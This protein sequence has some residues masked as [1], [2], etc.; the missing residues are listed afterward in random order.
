MATS[1]PSTATHV[2]PLGELIFPRSFI[3]SHGTSIAM[4]VRAKVALALSMGPFVHGEVSLAFSMQTLWL[5]KCIV[6]KYRFMGP[7]W[8]TFRRAMWMLLRVCVWPNPV[9]ARALMWTMLDPVLWSSF[10]HGN[11]FRVV[12][13]I[14]RLMSMMVMDRLNLVFCSDHVGMICLTLPLGPTTGPMF[15]L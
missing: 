14:G 9:A 12:H 5:S 11:Q 15:L 6:E 2:M 13:H 10:V 4:K 1:I 8:C 3:L 7:M